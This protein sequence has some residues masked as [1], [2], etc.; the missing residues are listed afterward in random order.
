MF[1]KFSKDTGEGMYGGD[2]W[3]MKAAGH[4]LK[5]LNKLIALYIPKVHFP[6][7]ALINYLG[8]RVIVISLLPISSKTLV[9]GS[10]DGAKHVYNTCETMETIMA[11]IGKLLNLR[12]HVVQGV[13]IYGPADLEGHKGEDGRFYIADVP[14]LFPP[15]YI[16]KRQPKTHGSIWFR[17]LRPEF[18]VTYPSPLSSD[19]FST[20]GLADGDAL[21]KDVAAATLYLEQ[22]C[23]PKFAFELEE[24]YNKEF[25]SNNNTLLVT[26]NVYK[27]FNIKNKL[28][29]YGINCRYLFLVWCHLSNSDLKKLLIIEIISRVV[30]KLLWSEMRKLNSKKSID[31]VII[32]YINTV[33]GQGHKSNLFWNTTLLEG[34]KKR[35]ILATPPSDLELVDD[36]LQKALQ[37]E[38]KEHRLLLYHRIQNLVGFTV[39]YVDIDPSNWISRIPLTINDVVISTSATTKSI[40]VIPYTQTYDKADDAIT[41]Y[42]Q[43]L[44]ARLELV[45]PLHIQVANIRD[46]LALLYRIKGKEYFVKAE[47]QFQKALSIKEAVYSNEHIEVASY[48]DQISQFYLQFGAYRKTEELLQR[49]LEIKKKVLGTEHA[50][51]AKTLDQIAQ[52][53][54]KLGQYSAAKTLFKQALQM[55]EKVSGSE[56]PAVA[57]TSYNLALLYRQQGKYSKAE[58]LYHKSLK[59]MEAR[60]GPNHSWVSKILSNLAQL[61]L[62]EGKYSEAEPLFERCITNKKKELGEYHLDTAT[63][64]NQLAQLYHK[65]KKY[66][67]ASALYK[68]ALKIRE[69]I[70]GVD[71]YAVGK[72]LDKLAE[73]EREQKNYDLANDYYIKALKIEEKTL[74]PTHPYYTKIL[75]SYEDFKKQLSLSGYDQ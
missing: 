11:Q 52:V 30:R 61:Y 13:S 34:I 27:T 23:I 3:A 8:W 20:M 55:L 57:T 26:D 5:S 33:F 65:Q 22:I 72:I 50:S 16:P 70:L 21:N 49:S 39:L 46:H 60:K 66:A 56:D 19:A 41:F 47:K 2:E 24:Y 36:L 75:N 43:E 17:L 71:H 58:P 69:D 59:I 10:A 68:D 62:L 38:S 31:K 6:L 73:L 53:Y 67:A 15:A 7:M 32:S 51:T 29:E 42:K 35:F 63:T 9:Y 48:L 64:M 54:R 28:H 45:G 12:E 4:E 18:M 25:N 14:R 74:G 44:K 37:I 40:Q 1:F